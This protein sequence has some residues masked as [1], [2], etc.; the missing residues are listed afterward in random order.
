MLGLQRSWCG[1]ALIATLF[2][3]VGCKTKRDKI[4]PR[5]HVKTNV[6]KDDE[7]TKLSLALADVAAPPVVASR[8]L[9]P[10]RLIKAESKALGNGVSV[11]ELTSSRDPRADLVHYRACTG[12]GKSLCYEGVMRR[13]VLTGDDSFFFGREGRLLEGSYQL[14]SR[15]C[16]WARRANDSSMNA[17][18]K[19]V[20]N[21]LG[22]RSL[23]C[24]ASSTDTIKAPFNRR[25]VRKAFSEL[26]DAQN[27]LHADVYRFRDSMQYASRNTANSKLRRM[28]NNIVNLGELHNIAVASDLLESTVIAQERAD[29][30]SQRMG[31][32]LADITKEPDACVNLD[33]YSAPAPP[34]PPPPQESEASEEEQARKAEIAA[35]EAKAAKLAEQQR[36][37]EEEAASAQAEKDR[38]AAEA[39]AAKA[40][41]AQDDELLKL[42]CLSRSSDWVWLQGK[43]GKPGSC[44]QSASGDV[45]SDDVISDVKDSTLY[46]SR[47][48]GSPVAQGVGY[49]LLTLGLVIESSALFSLVRWTAGQKIS[50]GS[51]MDKWTSRLSRP[52]TWISRPIVGVAKKI[53]GK[54]KKG[55]DEEGV[56]EDSLE[57]ENVNKSDELLENKRTPRRYDEKDPYPIEDRHAKGSAI[58]GGLFIG[59]ALITVGALMSEGAFGGDS[60][61]TVKTPRADQGLDLAGDRSPRAMLR[62][63]GARIVGDKDRIASRRQLIK[64]LAGR[65]ITE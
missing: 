51:R 19:K 27:K 44:T 11:L 18:G 2:A 24:G 8:S 36:A 15:S 33:D 17:Q 7:C 53:W 40:Q 54:R 64:R 32:N 38:Q 26:F 1:L 62:A 50:G 45:S 20:I 10:P 3:G 22:K 59:P 34:P 4:S 58:V 37:K 43:D 57:Y 42:D 61:R 55:Y 63:W 52:S 28:V 29:F 46:D 30:H 12:R 23:Y 60:A 48:I 21:Y 56:D 14:S 9:S 47:V 49:G 6:Q 41:A 13:I 31:M 16:V 65:L 25:A 35:S 39:A 5:P